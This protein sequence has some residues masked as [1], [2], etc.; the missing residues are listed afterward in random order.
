MGRG[1][2][3]K[4]VAAICPAA[5]VLTALPLHA[6]DEPEHFNE[7]EITPFVGY[8]GGGE[9]EDPADA[10]DR[11]LDG[12]TSFGIIAD[13]AADYWRHYELLF[14]QQST[15][16]Q[17]ETPIDIDV[18]YLQLGGIVSH[19]DMERVIPYFG[20]TFGAARLSPDGPGLDDETKLA[21]SV[22]TGFRVPIT[23]RIGVRFDAR[24]F[25]TLLNTD[26][27]LFC[28]SSQQG[29]TCRIRAKSDTFVQYAAAL[30]VV[31]GF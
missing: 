25:I 24:A 27:D 23:D 26:G 22:G 12:D 2:R 31:I 28:V 10:T 5:L 21:F 1:F 30:G 6:A 13:A 8:Q 11:D 17:G 9:F 16:V 29:A 19:P 4:L 18:Q 14:S 7:F 15:T 3:C 20:M